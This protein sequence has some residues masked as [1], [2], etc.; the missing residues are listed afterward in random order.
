MARFDVDY[1][2]VRQNGDIV[3]V[4]A[5]YKV[6]LT[7]EGEQRKGE[8][9][10]HEGGK[11]SFSV[12][13]TRNVFNCHGCGAGGNVIKL[14]QLLD[15]DKKNPR[16]AALHI[17]KL[18]GIKAKAV[19]DEE[20]KGNVPTAATATKEEGSEADEISVDSSEEAVATSDGK[21]SNRP[22]TFELKLAPVVT[23]ENT[24]ANKFVEERGLSYERLTELG[25]GIGQRGSM[26]DRLAIPIWNK[27]NELVAYSGRDIGLLTGKDEPKYK[28]PP[29]FKPELELYG[30]NIAQNF[31]RVVL[32]E[33]PL[34]VIKH[35]GVAA[36]FGDS[37]FGI[38]ALLGTSLSE[39]QVELLVE[40]SAQVIVC[41]DGDEDGQKAASIVAGKIAQ[42]GLWVMIR[43]YH[44]DR[45]PHHD[46]SDVFCRFVDNF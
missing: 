7:G 31:E 34:S 6:S 35:G 1:P 21:S 12:N 40:T 29:K 39:A 11:P 5:H 3:A 38:A 13:V 8:C 42:A 14:V 16:K 33:S 26:K 37:G 28:L 2:H 32:V 27:D 23:G 36:E 43:K 44:E 20:V 19:G 4:L 41:L 9:P 46:D 30:W 22:L 18:S 45:K 15:K 10:F 17:A 24:V 25:I